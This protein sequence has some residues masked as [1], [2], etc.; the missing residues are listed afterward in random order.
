MDILDKMSGKALDDKLAV[1]QSG[2]A[3]TSPPKKKLMSDRVKIALISGIVSIL[4]AAITAFATITASGLKE[5]A[6]TA[7]NQSVEALTTARDAK[8]LAAKTIVT[9]CKP[10][11]PSSELEKTYDLTDATGKLIFLSAN[12]RGELSRGGGER[13]VLRAEIK[14]AGEIKARDSDFRSGE[15]LDNE[16]DWGASASHLFQ[17]SSST[18]SATASITKEDPNRVLSINGEISCLEISL[19]DH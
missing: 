5:Q 15:N 13:V 9:Y 7:R 16:R 17:A 1:K 12:G 6:S 18:P 8:S 14:V 19:P 2:S 11:A 4:T 3:S 10:A